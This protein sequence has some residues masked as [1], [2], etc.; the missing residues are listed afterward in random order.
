M[1]TRQ[2]EAKI[3]RTP[4]TR[5]AAPD[6][7]YYT[8]RAAHARSGPTT[9]SKFNDLPVLV[10]TCTVQLDCG[11]N[12][13]TGEPVERQPQQDAPIVHVSRNGSAN[14]LLADQAGTFPYHQAHFT[15]STPFLLPHA[16]AAFHA[17]ELR[18]E[19]RKRISML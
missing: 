16:R 2:K 18:P 9:R 15:S 8:G 12:A 6:C 7:S 14:W 11:E 5:R 3:R 17:C 19:R 10:T 4:R 1:G 13:M